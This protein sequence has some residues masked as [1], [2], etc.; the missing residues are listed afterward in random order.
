MKID[1]AQSLI[2]SLLTSYGLYRAARE[3]PYKL[4]TW[5]RDTFELLELPAELGQEDVV[6]F[7]VQAQLDHIFIANETEFDKRIQFGPNYA[8]RNDDFHAVHDLQGRRVFHDHGHTQFDAIGLALRSIGKWQFQFGGIL[9]DDHDWLIAQKLVWYLNSMKAW[10]TTDYGPWENWPMEVHSSSLF[11][12]AGGL[13]RS[14]ALGLSVPDQLLDRVYEAIYTLRFHE[15]NTR[16]T[17]FA[18][19]TGIFRYSDDLPFSQEEKVNIVERVEAELVQDHGVIR[20]LD[21]QWNRHHGQPA[22]WPLGFTFLM[23]AWVALGDYEKALRYH[24]KIEEIEQRFGLLPESIC[25]EGC[26]IH[27]TPLGWVYAMHG[28]GKLRLQQHL[29]QRVPVYEYAA[30][31]VELAA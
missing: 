24:D 8:D 16:A 30:P 23:N 28:V 7:G 20:Y 25:S 10:E 29:E 17:D 27:N 12:I 15:S 21:D 31:A 2:S 3:G 11:A 19:L 18:L 26:C 22:Q 4:K 13:G 1:D 5:T 14:K 9:R 6:R